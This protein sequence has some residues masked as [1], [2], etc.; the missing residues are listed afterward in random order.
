MFSMS[1]QNKVTFTYL[2]YEVKSSFLRKVFFSFTTIGK[3]VVLKLVI[4][5]TAEMNDGTYSICGWISCAFGSTL[6]ATHRH[7]LP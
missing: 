4:N 6:T 1:C 2:R 5:V 3:S 7:T